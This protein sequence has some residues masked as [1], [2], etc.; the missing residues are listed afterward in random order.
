MET[1]IARLDEDH[2]VRCSTT[3]DSPVGPV[4]TRDGILQTLRSDDQLTAA[5]ADDVLRCVDE[6]GTSDPA[7]SFDELLAGNRAGPDECR[8]TAAEIVERYRAWPR[9]PR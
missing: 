4:T 2:Y 8:L 9:G 7:L 6:Y 3:T 5:A 1:L